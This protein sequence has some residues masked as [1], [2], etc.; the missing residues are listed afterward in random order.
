MTATRTLQSPLLVGRDPVLAVLDRRI[1]EVNAGHGTLLLFAGEAGIGKS[2]VVQAAIRKAASD[3]FRVAK[4][5]LSPQDLLVPLA[6]IGDLARSMDRGAFGELGPDLLGMRAGKG[7]DAL[8]NRRILVH[9]IADRIVAAID[10]PTVLAFEDLQW[11]DELSLE[12]IGELGRSAR[13]LPLLLLADYRL[14]ELPTG[15]IHRE[16]R[17]RLVTQRVGEEIKLERLGHDDTA[18]ITTLILGSG[19]PAPRDV[20]D[21][22][23]E[24]TNGIPL[25]IE[26]LLGA[27][28]DRIDGRSI[29]DAT[30]PETIEDAVLARASRLSPEARSVARAGSIIGRS[31]DPAVLA[32]VMDRRVEDLDGPL[33][34]LVGAAFLFPYDFVDRGY[35]DFR[36]QLLRDALYRSVPAIERRRLHARAA[37]FGTQL[38]GASDI[39]ASAHFERAGLRADAFRTALAGA[40]AAAAMT[41][42]FE[43]FELYRRAIANIP[44][45][46]SASELGDLYNAYCSAGFAVD[47]VAAIEEGATLARRY[48][49]DAGRLI[50]AA[51]T[52]VALSAHARRDVRPR[53]ERK[54]FLDQADA[55]LARIAPS[56]ERSAALAD[57]RL[58]QAVLELD[59][60]RLPE[61]RAL[62]HESLEH[63]RAAAESGS[64]GV[65]QPYLDGIEFRLAGRSD[66]PDD[67]HRLDVEFMLAMTDALGGDVNEGLDRMIRLSRAARD[68]QYEA[69]GVTNYRIAADVAARL[70]QYPAALVGVTEGL[71]YADEVEQSYCR[72]VMAATSAHVAWAGGRWDDATAQAGIELVEP[73]SRRG[74]LGSRAVLGFVAFGRGNVDDARELLDAALA[75]SR[76]S[77]EI[78]LVLPSLWGLAETALVAGDPGRAFDHCQE[79]LELA[80]ATAERAL[81]VPFVVTGVR[82]ALAARRPEVADR[83]LD[84][85]STLLAGW[86]PLAR[87]ALDH[88]GGL[89]KLAAGSTTAARTA[90][91]SAIAGWD[92]IGRIWEATW[93]RLDLGTG[94]VRANRYAEALLILEPVRR[95]ATELRSAPIL[96]RADELVRLAR[97]RGGEI[98]PWHPLTAREFEVAQKIADG[99]TNAEIGEELI[100]SPKT[101]SAHVEHILAKLAVSRRA[102][103]AVWVATVRAP[104]P[105]SSDRS[106]PSRPLEVGSPT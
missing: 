69:T 68:A 96:E 102:E 36:H 80:A 57:L 42:R 87:P 78:D 45:G 73:G 4:G 61:A 95:T 59:G 86:D 99:L 67:A 62:L 27:L 37:E 32:G 12:V 14:D 22:V 88:A 100:V 72:H 71:R 25:H 55:E 44:D 34:E 84:R 33:E 105:A 39:H 64:S 19:F 24:R 77:G 40:Q 51:S 7:A 48:F 41:S 43:A 1:A 13:T 79:A 97:A 8:S 47:D 21:A 81:L 92:R 6:S 3:G 31:F 76:P 9:E 28:G 38:V 93:A 49:L 106:T 63:W 23:Q 101:V 85:I 29:R 15:S 60:V 94:L 54:A 98:E 50:D 18:L 2:R 35:F 52:L 30:V 90:L 5:D 74:T 66:D 70:M 65:A 91:E 83:W 46:L 75:I 20:V 53:T 104:S 103:I 58:M 16:W 11:A 82:S 17:A 56:P 89:V 10:R 26:E